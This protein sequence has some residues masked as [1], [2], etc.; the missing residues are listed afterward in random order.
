VENI[1]CYQLKEDTTGSIFTDGVDSF[2]LAYQMLSEQEASFMELEH[3]FPMP[4]ELDGLTFF[5][6][7]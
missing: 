3:H 6:S 7:S 4:S 1:A 5:S 2:D